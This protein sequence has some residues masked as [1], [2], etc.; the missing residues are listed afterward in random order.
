MSSKS[1]LIITLGLLIIA[2]VLQQCQTQHACGQEDLVRRNDTIVI[3][4]PY[5]PNE[6]PPSR[7]CIYKFTATS[8]N[9]L[10]LYFTAFQIEPGNAYGLCAFDFL[11]IFDGSDMT[12]PVFGSF[13]DD[14]KPPTIVT[15]GRNLYVLFQADDTIQSTG[16]RAVVN[17][18]PSYYREPLPTAAPGSCTTLLRQSGGGFFS[19]GYPGSYN[20][21]ERCTYIVSLP[22]DAQY[23][24]LR[25]TSFDLEPS[26]ECVY[27]YVEVRD[28][29]SEIS[30]IIGRY[31]GGE[32]NKPPRLIESSGPDIHVV[33]HSDISATFEGFYAEYA[34]SDIGFDGSGGNDNGITGEGEEE[35][36]KYVSVC[37]FSH[38]LMTDR[39]GTVVSHDAYPEGTYGAGLTCSMVFV[40]SQLNEKVFVNVVEMDLPGDLSCNANGDYLRVI[41]GDLSSLVTD[42]SDLATLCGTSTGQYSSSFLYSLIQFTSDGTRETEYNG[43]KLVYSIYYDDPYGC[44]DDDF[45]C[46]NSRCIDKSLKCDGYDHCGD[47]SDETK[48]CK[49]EG[50]GEGWRIA[51]IVLGGMALFVVAVS[52]AFFIMKNAKK[53]PPPQNNNLDTNTLTTLSG[54]TQA[55]SLSAVSQPASYVNHSYAEVSSGEPTSTTSISAEVQQQPPSYSQIFN[56]DPAYPPPNAPDKK[57]LYPKQ[58]H[59]MFLASG[60]R[61]APGDASAMSTPSTRGGQLPP[62]MT[63]N[64]HSNTS[65]SL[66]PI[67][68]TPNE[69]SP[70]D[71]P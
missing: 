41:D 6:Y 65:S 52:I 37:D 18:V 22:D 7:N 45:H 69:K 64:Q 49:G 70:N 60:L 24:L 8:G 11:R 19:P 12:D 55:N 54:T 28:G 23:V 71:N 31:C 2:V 26:Y 21:D 56:N 62:L 33:F 44:Q 48:G 13:C 30:P 36:E 43:F 66:P 14:D 53:P 16:F 17:S 9:R 46:Q 42:Q 40:G 61:D 51:L 35:T 50:A 63:P 3:K 39:G 68:G 29:V 67:R 20:A 10:R 25:F 38:A 32:R 57:Q 1:S 5:Y 34:S 59:T 47:N 4:S 27:D 15:S 58:Q